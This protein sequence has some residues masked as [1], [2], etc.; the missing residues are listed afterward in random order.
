MK[1]LLI[2]IMLV[3]DMI[4][5]FNDEL[6]L[7]EP[8]PSIDKG[9]INKKL[10]SFI[11]KILLVFQNEYKGSVS[12]NEEVLTQNFVKILDFYSKKLPFF[13]QQETIQMPSDGVRRKV[14]IGVFFYYKDDDPF[15]T[16]EAKRLPTPKGRE[17]E[18]V[19][20]ANK[21]KSGGIERF[22]LNLHGINLSQSAIIGYVQSDNF[23]YWF[24]KIN[25]WIN[26][27]IVNPGDSE[28]EWT[29]DDLLNNDCGFR[30]NEYA[31]FNSNSNKVNNT[32]I[33]ILHYFVNLID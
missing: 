31:K 28:L 17:R 5:D 6:T 29:K 1:R 18:Y 20:G 2:F 14:D 27:L 3:I 30:L 4:S 32:R 26:E 13:F 16:I 24:K 9:T 8:T 10:I 22:K 25:E 23:K 21:K 11:E 15:F 19:I 12:I 33:N 7:N